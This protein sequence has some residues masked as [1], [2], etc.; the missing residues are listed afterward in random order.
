M[1]FEPS[2]LDDESSDVDKVKRDGESRR[3]P[4][5][6]GMRRSFVTFGSTSSIDDAE[7]E[8]EKGGCEEADLGENGEVRASSLEEDGC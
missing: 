8:T 1:T 3:E 6:K 7:E 4:S 5:P 2:E